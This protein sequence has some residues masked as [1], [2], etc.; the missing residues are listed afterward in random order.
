MLQQQSESM[1][2]NA[3][4]DLS[5]YH[6]TD[7]LLGRLTQMAQADQCGRRLTGENLHD[8]QDPGRCSAVG[9]H[10]F[11]EDIGRTWRYGAEDAYNGTIRFGNGSEVT[12]YRRGRPHVVVEGG[13]K[14]LTHLSN[15]VQV[16]TG[17][18]RSFTLVQPL[19]QD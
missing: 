10:A 11:S 13:G 4:L 1:A 15:G 8:E 17:D 12:L 7:T 5:F 3:P 19:R 16:A 14:R 9:R 18:D 6:R 2:A